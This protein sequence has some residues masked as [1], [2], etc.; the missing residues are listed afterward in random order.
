MAQAALSSRVLQTLRSSGKGRFRSRGRY[1]AG[2]VLGTKW[3]TSDQCN[4]TKIAVQADS[5]LV[6]DL[7]KHINVTVFAH[8]SYLALAPKGKHK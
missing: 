4:G 8:H 3:T 7:V 1:A 2:T 6:S 5:V